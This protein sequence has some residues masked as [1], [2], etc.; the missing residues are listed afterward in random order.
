MSNWQDSTKFKE[1][2]LVKKWTDM[3]DTVE[4]A[5]Q[6]LEIQKQILVKKKE[7]IVKA[8]ETKNG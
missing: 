4:D 6:Q 5:A 2:E 1:S 8:K 7:D 3:L